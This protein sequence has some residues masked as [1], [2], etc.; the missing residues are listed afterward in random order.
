MA[1]AYY[2]NQQGKHALVM[3][4]GV[5]FGLSNAIRYKTGKAYDNPP[6]I[7]LFANIEQ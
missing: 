2:A 4:K 7:N 6:K 3:G 5:G 1:Y